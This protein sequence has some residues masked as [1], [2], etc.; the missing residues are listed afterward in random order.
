MKLA[1]GTVQFGLSYGIANTRGQVSFEE[2]R[3][4]LVR[5][6]GAGVEVLD[7]AIDYG[8]AESALG[9]IGVTDWQIV[10]KLPPVPE[11][12]VDPADWAEAMLRGSLARLGRNRVDG[13]LLHRAE[14]LTGPRGAGVAAALSRLK[15]LGL[16]RAT[17]VSI[18]SPGVLDQI[19]PEAPLDIV[20]APFNVIDR[21]VESSGWAARL[22][23]Q[24][25]A[26]HTRSAF[27]QGLLLM[28]SGQR[29][30]AFARF[31]ALFRLWEGWLAE[32]GLTPL[33]GALGYALSRPGIGRVIIG[34]DSLRQ[35]DE[36]L[37]AAATPLPQDP[38]PELA[39]ME[40]ALINPSLWSSA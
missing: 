27:L 30:A 7:T 6:A 8:N 5:A 3:D 38:P 20:Q 37:A 36:V 1:L 33:Q 19:V 9:A 4:I 16:T 15:A 12:I 14:D 29:P 40:E 28:P 25:V 39:V 31:D 11:D 35:L 24:G 34:V 2:A 22:A 23:E 17:G 18:Y 26:L 21:R 13:L 32:A 10:T